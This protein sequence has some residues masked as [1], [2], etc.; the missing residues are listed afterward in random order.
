M[1]DFNMADLEKKQAERGIRAMAELEELI[2]QM[3]SFDL[4]GNIFLLNHMYE[5]GNYQDARDGLFVAAE[6]IALT[7]LKNKY[8]DKSS[9]HP[10]KH[11]ELVMKIQKL[12]QEIFYSKSFAQIHEQYRAEKNSLEEIANNTIRSESHIRNPAIPGHHL[13]FSKVLYAALADPIKKKFGFTI[14][15]SVQ[16]RKSI[17]PLLNQRLNNGKERIKEEGE[18]RALE[19]FYFRSTGELPKESHF[20]KEHAIAIN[21]YSRKEIKQIVKDELTVDF[22]FHFHEVASFTA[23]DIATTSGVP[24]K[25]VEAFF[26]SLAC[27]FGDVPKKDPVYGPVTLLNRKPVIRH[28]NR[29]II[30]S[31]PL[32]LFETEQ[33]VEAW[34]KTEPKLLDKWKDNRHNVLLDK[35]AELLLKL[36]PGADIRQNLYYYLDGEQH[37]TDGIFVYDRTLYIIEAKANRFSEAFKKGKILRVKN[38]LDDIVKKSYDQAI[39]TFQYIQNSDGLFEDK[40][41]RK[42]SFNKKDF[43]DVVIISLTLEPLGAITPYIKA[44]NQLGYF[45]MGFFPWIISIFDLMVVADHLD[46]PVMLPHY[47]KRRQEFLSHDMMR[48]YE[49]MDLLS[50]YLYNN[51]YIEDMV[52]EATEKKA[53]YVALENA[54]DQ[55]NNYYLELHRGNNKAAKVKTEMPENIVNLLTAINKTNLTDRKAVMLAI[56]NLKPQRL[57]TFS[58]YIKRVKTASVKDEK[59]HDCSVIDEDSGKTYGITYLAGC[60]LSEVKGKLSTYCIYKMTQQNADMWFAIGDIG[61]SMDSYL[62]EVGYK[63]QF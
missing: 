25:T 38:Q 41:R 34:I 46:L 54:T 57:K 28:G 43:S 20:S 16:I 5:V 11:N 52:R 37:E 8:V 27:A 63:I 19:I 7:A 17:M 60:N 44:T 4:L 6:I 47:I 32:F 45:D 22:F 13:E 59:I 12:G 3:E 36:L 35:G 48:V 24:E 10:Y 23:S 39:R 18:K 14:E 53:N 56:L 26:D 15:E 55:I 31:F 61:K 40:T 2:P 42:F 30:P 9:I 1:E 50:Y 21:K 49:E 58:E 51:L 62:I 29:Y 33:M